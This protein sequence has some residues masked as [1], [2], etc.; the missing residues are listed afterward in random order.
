[1]T[2][3]V[4]FLSTKVYENQDIG[5]NTQQGNIVQLS[6]CRVVIRG[7]STSMLTGNNVEHEHVTIFIN[8]FYFY[9]DKWLEGR[10]PLTL[11]KWS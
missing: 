10:T 6:E 9:N 4:T 1:M 5:T 3:L 8:Q 11:C 7:S 2:Q